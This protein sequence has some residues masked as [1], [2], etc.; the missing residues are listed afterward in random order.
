MAAWNIFTLWIFIKWTGVQ[1][2]VYNATTAKTNLN[3]T[4]IRIGYERFRQWDIAKQNFL[5][6]VKEKFRETRSELVVLGKVLSFLY[7]L[8]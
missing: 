7:S 6:Y 2:I 5:T 4:N 8:K 1:I 3:M